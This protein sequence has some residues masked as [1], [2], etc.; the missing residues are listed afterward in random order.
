MRSTSQLRCRKQQQA[1]TEQP[2]ADFAGASKLYQAA[3]HNDE[4]VLQQ[5]LPVCIRHTQSLQGAP[6]EVCVFPVEHCR[7]G[8]SS[9]RRLTYVRG[10][11]GFLSELA[12]NGE[13]LLTSDWLR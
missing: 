12:K 6:N 13:K 3:T 10:A 2:S 4:H 11:T 5:I 1:D 9:C 8:D 7:R